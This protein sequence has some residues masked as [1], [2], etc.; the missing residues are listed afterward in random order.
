MA[1][2]ATISPE[3]PANKG[4][5]YAWL[6]HEGTELIQQLAGN[7]WTDYN[8]HDPGVTALEQLCYVLTDLSY[9]AEF[10]LDTLL[11][12]ARSGR[13]D[14]RR[15]AL[16]VPR[17]ILPC[18]PL[19][20]N[21]Y[22]KLIVDRVQGV[23][24]VWLTPRRARIVDAATRNAEAVDGLYDI[25]L[26]AP[27]ADPCACDDEFKPEAIRERTERVYCRHRNLC[28][29]VHS[30]HVLEP[31]VTRVKAAATIDDSRTPEVILASLLFNV[32]KF[33][34]PELRRQPL[35]S[36][37]AAGLTTDAIFN[38]PLLR[39]G[40][41]NDDQLLPKATQIAISGIIR[42]M[43]RTPGVTGLRDVSVHVGDTVRPYTGNESIPV[44]TKNILQ[45]DTRPG[46]DGYAIQLYRKG[47]EVKPDPARVRRELD[48]LW[49][50]YR[51]TYPLAPQYLQHFAVPRGRSRDLR[52]YYSVQ[53]QYPNAYGI[54]ANGLPDNPGIARQAQA[55]QLKGYLL[56]YD[57]LL[58]NFL[59]QL[60]HVKDLFSTERELRQTYFYQYLNHSVP[61]VEPLLRPD[62]RPGLAAIVRSQDPVIDRRNR[63]L[64]FLL[65]LYGEALG[66]STLA[67]ENR[68]AARTPAA[69]QQEL[70]AKLALLHHLVAS[71]RNR[72]RG[73]DYLAPISRHNIA[74]ME[75]KSRIQLGMDMLELRP[76]VDVFAELAIEVVD[77][78]AEASFGRLLSG[79]NDYIEDN[80]TAPPPVAAEQKPVRDDLAHPSPLRG[81][82]VT[83]DFLRA[84]AAP[85][86]C[87]IGSLPDGKDI[88]VVCKSP[89]Q[90]Q[91]YFVGKYSD[92]ES[93]RIVVN[94][95]LELTNV[96]GRHARQLYIVEHTLLRFGCARN[97]LDDLEPEPHDTE[98]GEPAPFVYSFTITAVLPRSDGMVDD[99]DY[100]T[101]VHEVIRQNAPAHIVV[102]YCFLRFRQMRHFEK[103]YGAWRW[104]LR[105]GGREHI[106]HTSA[107][108]RR[109]L[110]RH[111]PK[112][113]AD[114]PPKSASPSGES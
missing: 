29:D 101:W 105:R 90:T 32:G 30:I 13:I 15:Q 106:I 54:N 40:F 18:N 57:Q 103:L 35:E 46:R 1:D 27:G 58:A 7:I 113:E 6:K 83:K 11:M 55:K 89:E 63:F 43:V 72:G 56:A 92:H 17:R 71:T 77:S 44:P 88:A 61:D 45:L 102:D 31:L 64:N 8:E 53:N 79:Y 20:Q 69:G 19:T 82:K 39:H 34:A 5:D 93:A 62:Y 24:N 68:D 107:R 110:V 16:F 48:R 28:E 21:D 41:I 81:Q 14:T 75:I 49:S 87:R 59:A 112:P 60:S 91:W 111:Q 94:Q 3:A 9:R 84:A 104:A 51:R 47:I 98:P 36:L 67:T 33:L 86:N 52:S 108:L 10:P 42:V 73:F 38:G 22:R 65:A 95:L 25:A 114:G 12:D 109:F 37:L 26:Y 70:D 99:R 97:G 2:D 66:A 96:L 4:L 23:A 76:H 74:G 80:F 85:G 78:D 100:R 50:D